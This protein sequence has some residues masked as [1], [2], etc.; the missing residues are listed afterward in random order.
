MTTNDPRRSSWRYLA[1]AIYASLLL[2]ACDDSP[3]ANGGG[4]SGDSGTPG[5]LGASC[6]S[7][8]DCV[9][10]TC[11]KGAATHMST[12]DLPICS[13]S[14]NVDGDCPPE[15]KLVCGTG[16]SGSSMCTPNCG[17]TNGYACVDGRSVACSQVGNTKCGQCGCPAGERC[18]ADGE[19]CNTLSDLG[20]ACVADGDCL[21]DNCGDD[22]SC[23]VAIGDPCDATNCDMCLTKG[24]YS[25]CSKICLTRG[26]CDGS[27]CLKPVGEEDFSCR[28]ICTRIDDPT[29]P[30]TCQ[31]ADSGGESE[32][33]FYCRCEECEV[34]M[35][36]AELDAGQQDMDAG[37]E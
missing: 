28:P 36:E 22:G 3:S 21:S 29:C 31:V 37:S 30:E 1:L 33:G 34:A 2:C 12:L 16:P 17:E 26:E 32:T 24:D 9:S 7:N 23:R 4:S 8:G 27:A 10:G 35:I 19:L 5:P 13:Q 14:C 11:L 25:F 6:E 15:S 20:T 18:S